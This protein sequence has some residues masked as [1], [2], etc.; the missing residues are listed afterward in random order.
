ME[1]N[2]HQNNNADDENNHRILNQLDKRTSISELVAAVVVAVDADD[3][4][5]DLVHSGLVN[6]AETGKQTSS[7][8]EK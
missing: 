4:L 8:R 6:T 3:I 1:E 5:V 2:N 7:H